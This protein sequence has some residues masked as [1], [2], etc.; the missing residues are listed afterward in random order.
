MGVFFGRGSLQANAYP[1][2]P[3]LLSNRAIRCSQLSKSDCTQPV[4]LLLRQ[5]P[6]NTFQMG[7]QP[8]GLHAFIWLVSLWSSY[9][10]TDWPDKCFSFLF[11]TD[12]HHLMVKVWLAADPNWILSPQ[13]RPRNKDKSLIAPESW[14]GEMVWVLLLC[15]H[16]TR[17]AALEMSE[18][19]KF[20]KN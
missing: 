5:A 7:E 14:V 9:V 10:E 3:V 8:D 12:C 13:S 19:I 16:H 1:L 6:Q 11:S 15:T 4:W 2:F 18:R 20:F 17:A